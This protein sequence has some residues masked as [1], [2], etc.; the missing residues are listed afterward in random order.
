MKFEAL[1]FFVS[2]D[3][4]LVT[5]YH[6]IED[7]TEISV[8]YTI[9]GE[10]HVAKIVMVD[11]S[12]DIAILDTDVKSKPLVLSQEF[13]NRMGNEVFALGILEFQYKDKLK[14]LLLAVSMHFLVIKMM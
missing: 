9:S 12:N 4:L 7:A 13:Q 6:V 8:N 1:Y 2:D 11:P 5:N 3:G 14:K 10:I